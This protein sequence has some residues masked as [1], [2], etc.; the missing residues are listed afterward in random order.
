MLCTP[1]ALQS[2]RFVS[3]LGRLAEQTSNSTFTVQQMKDIAKVGTSS[4]ERTKIV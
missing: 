4:K 1:S 3:E 2:K